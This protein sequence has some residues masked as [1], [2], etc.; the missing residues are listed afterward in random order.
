MSESET[1]LDILPSED[2]MDSTIKAA[3]A[4][5]EERKN[6]SSYSIS[7][8]NSAEIFINKYEIESQNSHESVC[9]M[10]ICLLLLCVLI[11]IPA[12][13]SPGIIMMRVAKNQAKAV[14]NYP[15]I[16]C[17]VISIETAQNTYSGNKK[18]VQT[19]V[20]AFVTY[21]FE[22]PPFEHGGNIYNNDDLS[23]SE[24]SSKIK[25]KYAIDTKHSCYDGRDMNSV[26]ENVLIVVPNTNESLY[27]KG[28]YFLVFSI[29]IAYTP[30]ICAYYIILG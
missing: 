20:D 23:I 24:F 12:W 6:Q 4:R 19:V 16:N 21:K 14:A 30:C 7:V 25:R 5:H 28:I 1:S 15:R 3:K 10:K 22:G 2:I 18:S 26:F 9:G 11:I 17:T 29:I 8:D 13:L 27:L